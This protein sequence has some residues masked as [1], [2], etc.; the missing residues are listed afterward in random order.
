MGNCS[1][2]TPQATSSPHTNTPTRLR[3]PVKDNIKLAI[4]NCN[5]VV[6]KIQEFQTFLS[7]TDP[8]LVLGTESWLKPEISNS[9]VFPPEY[10]IFRT[11]RKSDTKKS[12]GG[13]FIL[14]R[15]EYICSE[16]QVDTD[17]EFQV[18]ELQLQDQQN[19]KVCNS[20]VHHGLMIITLMIS[21][22]P[23]NKLMLKGKATSG[24]EGTSTCQTLTGV[25]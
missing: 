16:I 4:V 13:V 6:N 14:A 23:C 2:G 5:S 17:C 8:D 25:M 12:G 20:T 9:E 10:T 21:Q 24:L 19:V 11:D 22:M 18:V 15:R 7:A 1:P 3:T